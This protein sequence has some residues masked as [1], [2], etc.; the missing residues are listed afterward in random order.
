MAATVIIPILVLADDT[1]WT[2]DY[3]AQGEILGDPKPSVECTIFIGK[4][5]FTG[6]QGVDYTISHLHV[7]TKTKFDGYLDRV[8]VNDK[9]WDLIFPSKPLNK[10]LAEFENGEGA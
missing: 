7:F 3:S 4:N 1:L 5:F 9:Y 10:L 8:A 2:V 6:M